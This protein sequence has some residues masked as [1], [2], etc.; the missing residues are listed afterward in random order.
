MSIRLITKCL[1][2]PF[3]E[4]LWR[5]PQRPTFGAKLPGPGRVG[6]QTGAIFLKSNLEIAIKI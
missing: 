4:A 2:S 1:K 6:R 5:E 3:P